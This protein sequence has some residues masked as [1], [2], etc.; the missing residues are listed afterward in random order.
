LDLYIEKNDSL[1]RYYENNTLLTLLN[2]YTTILT[3]EKELKGMQIEN[4]YLMMPFLRKYKKSLDNWRKNLRDHYEQEIRPLILPFFKAIEKLPNKEKNKVYQRLIILLDNIPTE[5][6][7]YNRLLEEEIGMELINI[8]WRNFVDDD[9]DNSPEEKYAKKNVLEI[10]RNDKTYK[11]IEDEKRDLFQV[12]KAEE[13]N[14]LAAMS[15]L[16]KM[17]VTEESTLDQ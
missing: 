6:L 10:L 8:R 17:A 3:N 12:L 1:V 5:S 11:L 16:V 2:T 4:E 9:E 7:T 15:R 14:F 13:K